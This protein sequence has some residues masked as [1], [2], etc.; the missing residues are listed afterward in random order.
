MTPKPFWAEKP[1]LSKTKKKLFLFFVFFWKKIKTLCLPWTV[2]LF[3][4]LIE[5]S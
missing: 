5:I 2:L 1:N 4:V 3:K